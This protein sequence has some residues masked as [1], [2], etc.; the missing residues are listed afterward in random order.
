MSNLLYECSNFWLFGKKVVPQ[1]PTQLT[2]PSILHPTLCM[3]W[4]SLH[5]FQP[6]R[7]QKFDFF[8]FYKSS[9]NNSVTKEI[10]F[11]F[12]TFQK[13]IPLFS[14]GKWHLYR[15]ML[16]ES[17]WPE[18]SSIGI[19]DLWDIYHSNILKATRASIPQVLKRNW[20]P[21]NSSK[22][23]TAIRRHRRLSPVT[24]RQ[25]FVKQTAASVF[26]EFPKQSRVF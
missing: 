11:F 6:L 22:V 21:Q 10:N 16:M 24:E 19:D 20:K 17:Y 14:K 4:P 25:L 18:S 9:K 1:T 3:L 5:M 2:K 8:N 7:M 13:K 23:R 12:S 26:G 15:T